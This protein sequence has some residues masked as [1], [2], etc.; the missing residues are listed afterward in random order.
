MKAFLG[1]MVLTL[2]NMDQLVAF[3]RE[4]KATTILRRLIK[5]RRVVRTWVRRRT[6]KE[7]K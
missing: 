7:R 6:N 5:Q 3:A 4:H 1:T 2:A